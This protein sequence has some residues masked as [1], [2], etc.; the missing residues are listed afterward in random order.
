MKAIARFALPFVL[1]TGV[2]TAVSAEN[3]RATDGVIKA[4]QGLMQ[5]YSH[6]LG[7]LGGMAKGAI[8]YDAD[9]AGAA[10]SSLAMLSKID[11]S[12]MWAPG[13]DDMSADGTRALPDLWD[14][15]EDVAK[16]AMAL[17]EAAAAMEV[18]AATSLE[19]LQ[20][21]MGPLGG[22]CGACH[23]AYRAPAN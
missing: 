2:V 14:N 18:A 21:A 8:P 20:G 1:A 10:A 7:L 19:A 5:L 16:K 23:K 4:R 15:P 13:S 17:S 11:T 9:S 22:T 12:R 3:D 6:N